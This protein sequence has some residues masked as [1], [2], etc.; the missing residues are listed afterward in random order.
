MIS[1]AIMRWLAGLSALMLA[2]EI[3]ANNHDPLAV[4][5]VFHAGIVDV[6]FH[7]AT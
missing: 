5:P 3:H 1:K 2:G 6:S 4:N 7:D